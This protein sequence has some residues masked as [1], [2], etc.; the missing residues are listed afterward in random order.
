MNRDAETRRD[1]VAVIGLG[2]TGLP[3]ARSL[4]AAGFPLTVYNRTA[5]RAEALVSAGATLA[6]SPRPTPRTTVITSRRPCSVGRKRRTR[7]SCS[8]LGR[9][10]CRRSKPIFRCSQALSRGIARIGN[11]PARASL[12]KLAG[13]FLLVAMLEALG[14][15]FAFAEK[16]GLNRLELLHALNGA[17]FTSPVYQSNGERMCRGSRRRWDSRTFDWS[18]AP[19]TSSACQC[20]PPASRAIISCRPS[21]AARTIWTG[22]RSRKCCGTRR[23]SGRRETHTQAREHPEVRQCRK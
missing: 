15:V 22:R 21:R 23:V 5:R 8:C 9:D 2:A 6:G 13:N 1:P 14:E 18:S 7:P 17:L 11:D 12:M 19:R 4:L 3:I 20:R 16:A 10:R